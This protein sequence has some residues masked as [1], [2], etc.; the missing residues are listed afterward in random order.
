MVLATQGR[1]QRFCMDDLEVADGSGKYDVQ[2][3]EAAWFGG[4]DPGRLGDYYRV[5]L[6]ALGEGGRDA[7]EAG[8][9]HSV[10]ACTEER[11]LKTG[12][13]QHL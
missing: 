6:E 4:H 11:G 10:F 3:L 9:V 7:D 1:G 5:E 13:D 2:A 8:R 12:S